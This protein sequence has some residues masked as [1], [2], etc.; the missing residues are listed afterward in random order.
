VCGDKTPAT[1]S[2]PEEPTANSKVIAQAEAE[3]AEAAVA[4]EA[5]VEL[6]SY[7]L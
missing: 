5:L 2:T 1:T 3:A 4:E 6:Y 7:K